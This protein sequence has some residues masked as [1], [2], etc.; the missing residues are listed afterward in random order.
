MNKLFSLLFLGGTSHQFDFNPVTGFA[1]PVDLATVWLLLIKFERLEQVITKP[2]NLDVYCRSVE[3][4]EGDDGKLNYL[5]PRFVLA[6]ACTSS[7]VIL[8]YFK[9][10]LL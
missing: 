1:F 9:L 8:Y 3:L 6:V 5:Y 4:G 2:S 7:W 10:E